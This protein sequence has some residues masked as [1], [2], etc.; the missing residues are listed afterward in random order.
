[1]FLHPG[2]LEVA[3]E[4]TSDR[5]QPGTQHSEGKEANTE[6]QLGQLCAQEFVTWELC[7]CTLF[8]RLQKGHDSDPDLTSPEPHRMLSA[9]YQRL[10]TL[11]ATVSWGLVTS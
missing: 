7:T 9:L 8:G 4:M 1:M 6:G 2:V 5:A 11:A 3:E 10:V